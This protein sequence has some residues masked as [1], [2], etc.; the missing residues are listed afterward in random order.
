MDSLFSASEIAFR[1]ELR[2]FFRSA[3]PDGMRRKVRLGQNLSAQEIR[4]WHRILDAK[5]WAAP[6]W[7]PA[8]GGTGWNP[9]QIHMYREELHMACAPTPFAI[10]ISLAGPL[11]IAFGSDEQKARFLPGIKNLDYWFAQGFSEPD[12]GSDL[13]SLR[14]HAVRDGDSYVVTGQKAWTTLAQHANWMF[15]LVRTSSEARK[16]DGLTFLLID[17]SSPGVTVRPVIS[18][19]RDHHVNEVFLDNVRVPVAN[20]VGEE[21]RAWSYTKYLLTQERVIGARAAMT[22]LKIAKIKEAAARLVEDGV[23][24]SDRP[25]LQTR[26]AA[27]EVELTALEIT[28]IRVLAEMQSRAAETFDPKSSMLKLKGS[29]LYQ[30][31]DELLVDVLGPLGLPYSPGFLQ[32]EDDA[33]A[34]VPDWACTAMQKYFLNR[35]TTIYAGSAEVQ[36]NILA[37]AILAL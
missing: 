35:A 37:K 34:L 24:L 30:R 21:G 7:D 1:E 15:T 33:E 6:A 29:E 14:T 10:N 5:G 36:H 18:I 32:G 22:K 8:W 20:R 23:P 12:A 11:I 9:M 28:T 25:W 4:D 19:D 16:Q 27:L 26:L 17:M 3:V 31:A 2:R 13:A